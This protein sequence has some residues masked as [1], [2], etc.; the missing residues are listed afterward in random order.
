MDSIGIKENDLAVDAIKQWWKKLE[1]SKLLKPYLI[2]GPVLIIILFYLIF[3]NNYT[4]VVTFS[5]LQISIYF[6]IVSMWMLV[7]IL[8]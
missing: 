2:V 8:K 7:W 4:I 3:S 6:M 5:T 1:D